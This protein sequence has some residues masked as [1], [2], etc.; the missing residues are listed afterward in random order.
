MSKL[1]LS[2]EGRVMPTLGE[3]L[4]TYRRARKQLDLPA[5]G[6]PGILYVLARSQGDTA[7]PLRLT[8]NGA[9]VKPIEPND[10]GVYGWHEV[11]VDASLLREGENTFEFWTE[12]SAM[13]AWALGIEGGHL[14]P[15]S[16]L[17]D[18]S[19]KSWRCERM[20]YLNILRGEYVV[21]MRLA[22]GEDPVPAAVVPEDPACPRLESLRRAVPQEARQPGPLMGRVRAM[23]SWLASSWEHTSSARATQY[24]PW[25]A[26]TILAWGSSQC[27][28]SGQRPIA[29]CVHYGA[30][31]VSF[32]QAV[33]IP[34]R[35]AV[36]MGTPNG[37]DGH[38][39]AEVWFDEYGKW[40]MV[41]PNADAICVK[42]GTPLSMTEIQQEGDDLRG[43]LEWGAGSEFQRTFPHMVDFIRDNIEKGV[44]FRHRSVWHRADLISHPEL[45]P[46]GHG[47]ISYCETGL[48]W[49]KRDLGNFGM[50]PFFAGPEYFDAPP[51]EV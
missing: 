2:E 51:V 33:G 39:V 16:F 6:E 22:E 8:V 15:E 17:S 26:E 19:G 49:E 46:P 25:D 34:A 24:S 18:D 31:F 27:G 1:Y 4:T 50:F 11:E 9:E 45:S 43:V 36:L 23:S 35:C 20:G 13:N 38:F 7:P 44:C 28:H 21:R 30:A 37:F 29:M 47:S 14:Y 32:C 3:E 10:T 5:T 42:D 12:T 40:V 48:V 41:D